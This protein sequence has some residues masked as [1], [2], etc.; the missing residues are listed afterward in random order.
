[1]VYFD[2]FE[3]I[4]AQNGQIWVK[5]A[6]FQTKIFKKWPKMAKNA[7]IIY[8]TVKFDEINEKGYV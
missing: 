1:M 8:K 6:N 4:F 5:M 7:K 3:L 2:D